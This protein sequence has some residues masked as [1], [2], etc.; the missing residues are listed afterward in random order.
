MA[1]AAASAPRRLPHSR[2]KLWLNSPAKMDILNPD[3]AII[4][5]VPVFVKQLGRR[6]YD[7]IIA[8]GWAAEA[9]G[10]PPHAV[11]WVPD[12]GANWAPRLRSRKG[13]DPSEWPEDLRMRQYPDV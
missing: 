8:A 3:M 5:A 9:G 10:Y 6:P 11:P 1:A 4:W 2:P 12:F 7:D 13:G